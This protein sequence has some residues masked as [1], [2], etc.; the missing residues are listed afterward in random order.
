LSLRNGY[1]K[2]SNSNQSIKAELYV[3]GLLQAKRSN[4]EQMSEIVKD[5]GYHQIQHFISESPWEAQRVMDSVA[6][7]TDILFSNF[8]EVH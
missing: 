3:C 6:E 2:T 8:E 4:M 7:D 5:A 1:F